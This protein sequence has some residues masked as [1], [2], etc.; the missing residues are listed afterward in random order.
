MALIKIHENRYDPCMIP[1]K[2]IQT[3]FSKQVR[4]NVIIVIVQEGGKVVWG[5][6][7]GGKEESTMGALVLPIGR[8]S[9]GLDF[10]RVKEK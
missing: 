2:S 9:K 6:R 5:M 10:W 8:I 4:H 7:I 1:A 3:I